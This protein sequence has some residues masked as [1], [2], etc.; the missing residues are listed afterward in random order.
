MEEIWLAKYTDHMYPEDNEIFGAY[1]TE[2]EA[3][4]RIAEELRLARS[5]DLNYPDMNNKKKRN[6][7]TQRVSFLS[8]L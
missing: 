4:N 3:E 5:R 1:A 6:Y 8:P 7:D 2:Q